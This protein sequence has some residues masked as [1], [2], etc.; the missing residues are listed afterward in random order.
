MLQNILTRTTPIYFLAKH[1]MMKLAPKSSEEVFID[2]VKPEMPEYKLVILTKQTCSYN[3]TDLLL[4]EKH[5][6]GSG[7]KVD[8]VEDHYMSY[9]K[10]CM[11]PLLAY[12]KQYFNIL[13]IHGK[14]VSVILLCVCAIN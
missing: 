12:K 7:G 4:N 1:V 5:I 13:E 6:N 11:L 2:K 8:V 9:K 10:K 3:V 14:T